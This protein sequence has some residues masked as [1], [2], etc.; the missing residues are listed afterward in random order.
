M[1][2]VLAALG[3]A[4]GVAA[5][6]SVVGISVSS[7]AEVNR[8]LD[9]LGTNLLRVSPGQDLDGGRAQL[10][11]ESVVMIG[12]IGPVESVAATGAVSASVYR[13]DQIPV[14]RTGSIAVLAARPHLAGTVGMT[15]RTGRWL[16]AAA[17]AYP[18]VVLGSVAAERVGATTAGIRVWLGGHWFGVVGVLA[19][20]PLAPE[21]DAAAI[22]GWGVAER[23][24]GFDGIPTTVYVRVAESEVVDVRRVLAATAKPAAPGDVQVSRPSDAL[25]ARVAT[26]AT[27]N[28]LLLGL[29]AIA[30]LVGGLGVG[31]TM[32]ISVLER[33][34]EIGL[35]RSLG[36]TRGQIRGQFLAESLLL[37]V[38]G[39]AGGVVLG[40][41]VT[42]A[43]AV[44]RGWPTSVPL[45]AALG[46][47]AAT[48]VV[49]AVAGVYPAV[50]AS[51]MSPT[52]ALAAP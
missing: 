46:G 6:V 12:R 27:L 39:G 35:R 50:R 1:R 40:T 18:Q 26:N 36:A 42:T 29:G 24:L 23:L 38:A 41:A 25:A 43:Y 33:R 3:V 51:R 5:M 10:T 32:V 2:V 30:L 21:L 22:V 4:V 17:E 16:T 7:K 8:R 28:A 48:V 13:N 37:S 49:G 52:D 20:V 11:A 44:G 45:W 9:R 19:P 34:P 31:N 15:A 47:L 14:G